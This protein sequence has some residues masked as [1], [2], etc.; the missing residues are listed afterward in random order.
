M[1]W[2]SG[3]RDF[4]TEERWHHVEEPADPGFGV[5]PQTGTWET[6]GGRAWD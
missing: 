1:N 2:E 3:R 6:G 5:A 4:V